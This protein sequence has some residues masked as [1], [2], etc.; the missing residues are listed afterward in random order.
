MAKN[1]CIKGEYYTEYYTEY[2]AIKLARAEQSQHWDIIII[3]VVCHVIIMC[4]VYV[5]VLILSIIIVIFLGN[6]Q[7]F[8][9][10]IRE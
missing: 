7:I 8:M 9:R 4:C 2:Y 10:I 6:S 1:D 5:Y 3:Y